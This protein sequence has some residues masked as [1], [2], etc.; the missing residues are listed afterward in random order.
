MTI[1]VED[2]FHV[3]EVENAPDIEEWA[4][5]ESCVERNV[6]RLLALLRETNTE[7]TCFLL[8][9]VVDRHPDVAKRITDAGHEIAT[10]GYAHELVNEIGPERF[11]HDIERSIDTIERAV[12]VR[13]RGYRAPGFSITQ[14]ASW[15]FEILADLGLEF[16]ASIFPVKSGHGGI[17][18][19][20]RLPHCLA[21]QDERKLLEFPVSVTSLFGKQVAFCGGGYL[22]FFPYAFIRSRIAAANARGEPVIVYLHPRDIDPDHPR[23]EMPARRRFKSYVNLAT[24]YAKLR[25]LLCEFQFGTVSQALE[26]DAV[27]RASR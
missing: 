25:R 1:D 24:T 26:E 15:A 8:G 12:G 9:W 5:L 11:R 10:H 14:E 22:R 27:G 17:R 19:A 18:G 13:P 21:L 20:N 16:D 7:S 23:I 2:W 6:D 3:L 4:G